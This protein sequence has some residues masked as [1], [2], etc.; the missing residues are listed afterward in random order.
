MSLLQFRDLALQDAGEPHRLHN[1]I[2]SA[3]RHPADP[4]LLDDGDKRLFRRLARLQERR[5]VAAGP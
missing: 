3:R 2:D 4:G 1:L 5:E